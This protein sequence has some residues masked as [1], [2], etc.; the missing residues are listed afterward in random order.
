MQIPIGT[1][2]LG[3]GSCSPCVMVATAALPIELR[4]DMPVARHSPVLF[5]VRSIKGNFLT[6]PL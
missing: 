5:L 3:P 4:S 6:T 2:G 1:P